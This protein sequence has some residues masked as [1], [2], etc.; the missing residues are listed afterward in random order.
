[1]LNHCFLF[2]LMLTAAPVTISAEERFTISVDEPA[3]RFIV[4]ESSDPLI[5][6]AAKDV[7]EDLSVRTGSTFVVVKRDD[8]AASTP[9]IRINVDDSLPPL[10]ASAFPHG[11]HEAFAI[12]T[13]QN[14]LVITGA[15]VRGTVY[16]LFTLAEKMGISPWQW[17]A[18]VPVKKATS[19]LTLGKLPV[20]EGPAVKYRG[21]F[22]NDEDWG[23][24]PWA[25]QTFEP[26][27]ANIGPRTYEKVFQLLLR[28]KANTIW[29]A[30]HPGTR[31]FFTVPGNKEMAQRY[32]I[33][34]GSSHA[35]PMLRNNVDEWD[36]QQS[37]DFNYT[38]NA[39]R[40]NKYWRSRVEQVSDMSDL[41]MFTL[42]MRGIHDS[43]MEGINSQQQAKDT[44]QQAI[45]TQRAQLKAVF[46]KPAETLMQMFTPYKEVLSLYEMGLSVPD[47]VTLV[48]PD[49]NYGYIRRHSNRAEQTRSGGAGVYYHL[50]YWGRPHDYLWLSSTH[51]ALIQFEMQRAFENGADRIWIANV[52]DIKPLEY[53]MEWFLHLGWHG[54]DKVSDAKT[55]ATYQLGR[56]F[57]ISEPQYAADLLFVYY[58]LA[59]IRRPEFMGW[60]QT[61][62]TI[63]TQLSG[64]NGKTIENRLQQYQMLETSIFELSKSIQPDE[65]SAWFQ[66][67]SYP[68]QASSEMNKKW[69]FRHKAAF[70]VS[71]SVV[72]KLMEKA[73]DAHNTIDGLTQQYNRLSE[74]K[75][76]GMM[77]AAP[78][79]LPVFSKPEMITLTNDEKQKRKRDNN[80][81]Q[82]K[83]IKPASVKFISPEGYSW[84]E[85]RDLGYSGKALTLYPLKQQ[86]F[87]EKAAVTYLF[88]LDI[89][90]DVT[91]NVATLPVHSND[92]SH[93]I[94]ISLA[95]KPVTIFTLNTIG[96]SEQWKQGV[97]N[98][99]I[100]NSV[101]LG[102][103]SK[104]THNVTLSVNQNGIV[105]DE[106]WLSEH[107][108]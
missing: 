50:S 6:W 45:N 7:A 43:G 12:Y 56:D 34:V 63:Q 99:R 82:S 32:R 49:D 65:Q 5:E 101:N 105:I 40:V 44:L 90:Q 30:M 20:I 61:E 95:Q 73:L 86:H 2:F 18:N 77:D 76:A 107:G 14:S 19:P 8:E 80:G 36:K 4:V 35:E 89:A 10:N 31:A 59:F 39:A 108:S 15:D 70:T 47:D 83:Q 9:F 24:L 98:N 46:E 27:T 74:G 66:L 106:V 94:A 71:Q 103:L 69:L 72:D 91:L 79:K 25:S 92:F 68:V 51:P 42:G 96:R 84:Q 97:L 93:E 22:I 104:G 64:W 100:Q 21:I 75:W 29:P 28:L 13:K 38:N 81:S 33:H 3:A 23:M 53:N 57:A 1:M 88:N 60:S 17:W 78:R 11:N 58:H 102:R 55:F 87:S 67:M 16:G 54:P 85:V 26:D 48:W 37:G 52:G 41:A 62:P